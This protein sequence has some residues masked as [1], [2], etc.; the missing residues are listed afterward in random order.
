[1]IFN[2]FGHLYANYRT[3]QSNS[4]VYLLPILPAPDPLLNIF[5][6]RTVLRKACAQKFFPNLL[7]SCPF[8][9]RKF[10]DVFRNQIKVIFSSPKKK[11]EE[12]FFFFFFFFGSHIC[13]LQLR[14]S[15]ILLVILQSEPQP[16]SPCPV[17]LEPTERD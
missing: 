3:V 5:A 12:K 15:Q 17:S 13:S 2:I 14:R 8:F 16:G 9:Y 7:T 1:M 6:F 10:T 11:G 4:K